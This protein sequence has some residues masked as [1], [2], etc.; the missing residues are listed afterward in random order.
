MT[1]GIYQ[2]LNTVN[3][4]RYIGQSIQVRDRLN[5]HTWKLRNNKH[6]NKHLQAAW[7]EYGADVFKRELI[8]E[9][10]K[11]D[12]GFY[13]ESIING[14]KSND[15]EL[16][17]NLR[18]VSGSN[19]GMITSRMSFKPGDKFYKFTLIRPVFQKDHN[20]HWLAE[21]ECG[22]T[23]HIQPSRA[24]SGKVKSCGCLHTALQVAWLKEQHKKGPWNKGKKLHYDVWNKGLKQKEREQ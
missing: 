14:Y 1:V 6:T 2:I 23:K 5:E 9:C 22:K 16:G 12:L 24:R 8:V 18:N 4:K 21:C 7:N 11:K 10:E 20:W 19:A 3:G 15:K 13:E 17:Y